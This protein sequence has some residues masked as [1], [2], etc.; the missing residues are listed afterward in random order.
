MLLC[1]AAINTLPALFFAPP[2]DTLHQQRADVII[3]LGVPAK[4]DG[5]P[6]DMMAA[7][8]E[9]GVELFKQGVAPHM[10][11]SGTAAHN[12]WVEAEVMKAYA[13]KLGVP[14]E[15]VI[16]EGKSQNTAQNLFYSTAAMAD[17]GWTT[18]V[19]VTSTI[20]VPRA[21][22]FAARHP[23]TYRMEGTDGG[24]GTALNRAYVFEWEHLLRTRMVL[25]D[26]LGIRIVH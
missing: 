5:T 24:T 9:R 15:A 8:V 7:R 6:S 23:I 26:F 12:K 4:V 20:H 21:A 16:A 2:L 10:I 18:A 1:L 17:H 22:Y 3:V 19:I 13:Q 25:L 14:A 11:V